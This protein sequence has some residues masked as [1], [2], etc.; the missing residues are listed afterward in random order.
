MFNSTLAAQANTMRPGVISGRYPERDDR[1]PG[2]ID[3][4]FSALQGRLARLSI[5]RRAGLRKAAAAIG[6]QGESLTAL[7]TAQLDNLRIELRRQFRSQGLSNPLCI[8][9]FALIRELAERTIHLRHYDSQLMAGWV[10][11]HGQAGGNG[12]RRRKNPG[13]DSGGGNCRP[14]RYPGACHYRQRILS[15]SGMHKR[16]ARSISRLA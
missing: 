15:R 12:D 10:M 8:Q 5:D 4:A 14:G 13:G 1:E 11:L 2:W 3:R 6:R 9:A 16:W 7:D